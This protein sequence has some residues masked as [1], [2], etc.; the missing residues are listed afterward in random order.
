MTATMIIKSAATPT[1]TM[2]IHHQPEHSQNEQSVGQCPSENFYLHVFSFCSSFQSLPSGFGP[3]LLFVDVL[4]VPSD[5]LNVHLFS[6]VDVDLIV[7]GGD[8]VVVSSSP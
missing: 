1:D 6:V 2:M 7:G 8:F 4:F 3:L 5:G